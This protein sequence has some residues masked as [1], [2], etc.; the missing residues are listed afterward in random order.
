MNEQIH[1]LTYLIE[2]RKRLLICL[3]SVT[4]LFILLLPAAK[5]LYQWLALPLLQHL[6]ISS[7]LIATSVTAPFLTPLKLSFI[8]ALILAFPGF[9]YQLWAFLTPALYQNERYHLWSFLSIGSLL[10]LLGMAFCYWLVLPLLFNFLLQA[11]PVNVTVLP[12]IS[13]YLDFVLQLLLA[14]GLAFEVPLIMVLLL[15]IGIVEVATLRRQRPYFIVGAFIVGML[16]APDVLSQLALAVPL[17]VLFE[18]GLWWG[19][20]A[21]NR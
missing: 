8:C 9:L 19:K 10:F 3:Y 4:I 13:Q 5:I 17:C 1:W 11:T 12:D 21:F 2:L 7:T 16:V 20:Y 15:R 6:P 18:I 14:F